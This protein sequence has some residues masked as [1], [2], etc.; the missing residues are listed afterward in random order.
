MNLSNISSGPCSSCPFGAHDQT[1]AEIEIHEKDG[2]YVEIDAVRHCLQLLERRNVVLLSGRQGSGKSRNGLFYDLVNID[3]NSKKFKLTALEKEKM[4]TK[5]CNINRISIFEEN[6]DENAHG[7][8]QSVS[9]RPSV[10]LKREIMN[11]I[12]ETDP[13]LGF[14]NVVEYLLKIETTLF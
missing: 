14:Q 1:S 10:I 3:L 7:S 4:L 12:I 6:E 9:D 8:S 2:I 13:F 5:Y 11:E